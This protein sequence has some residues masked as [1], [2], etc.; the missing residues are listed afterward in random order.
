MQKHLTIYQKA[1][2]IVANIFH[3]FTTEMVGE[4]IFIL[5]KAQEGAHNIKT[6]SLRA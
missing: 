1:S 2:K 6:V 4:L 3:K 5:V